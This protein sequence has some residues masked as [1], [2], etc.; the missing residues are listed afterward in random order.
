MTTKT[1]EKIIVVTGAS[2][3]L[4]RLTAQVLAAQG[5]VVYATM[6][7]VRGANGEARKELLAGAKRAGDELRVVEIDV[8]SE[9]CINR[10][11]DSILEEA[12][13]I[14]VVVNNAG[15]MNVGVSEAYTLEAVERQFDV[16]FY[17]M[18]R[19]NRAVVPHMR[20]RRSGLLIQLS[21]LAGRIVFPF[22]GIY[23]ASKFAVEALAESYR[24]ELSSFGVDSI[25][26]EPGPFWTKLIDSSPGADDLDRLRS[27]GRVASTPTEILKSFSES[28]TSDDAPDP[29]LVATAISQLVDMPGER[30]LR[31]V[32]G[33]DY[34]V[35]ALNRAVEPVQRGFLEALGMGG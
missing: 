24:Y 7:S 31:T 16:N 8:T 14:D 29:M 11:I 1:K 32:V 12:G 18:V 25:I 21:S 15:V 22:F 20:Q 28:Q 5:H 6:R 27:Y 9:E 33:V 26:V 19:M 2:S 23:C 17:G 13:R 30:P 10:G 34:G 3:G 35:S 4:G